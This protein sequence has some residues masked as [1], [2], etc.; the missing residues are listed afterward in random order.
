[1]A[2]FLLRPNSLVIACVRNLEDPSSRNL[3]SLPHAEDS[4]LITL[5]L[6]HNSEKDPASMAEELQAMHHVG[7]LD[8]VVANAA[9]AKHYGPTSTLNIDHLKEHMNVNTYSVLLLFQATKPLLQK[10]ADKPKF[11]FIG[12]PIS[13]ITDMENCARAPLGAYGVSKLAANYFVRK[14]HF[15]N[16]WLISFIVD[17][18]CVY[19][20]FSA[21]IVSLLERAD[22]ST[23]LKGMYRQIWVTR[24]RGSWAGV[25]RLSRWKCVSRG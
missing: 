25:R 11:V 24:A 7:K 5:K 16:K 10:S 14:F 3:N 1:M 15:E 23:L 8:V 6:D 19:A 18:G 13:T 4:S 20:A 9:I 17:P 21:K 2:A 22:A 12:A